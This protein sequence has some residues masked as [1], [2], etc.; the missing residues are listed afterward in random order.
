MSAAWKSLIF[1]ALTTTFTA[2][3]EAAAHLDCDL[4]PPATTTLSCKPSGNLDASQPFTVTVA[5]A[6]SDF[7]MTIKYGLDPEASRDE[8]TDCSLSVPPKDGTYTCQPRVHEGTGYTLKVTAPSKK[9]N[10]SRPTRRPPAA[11]QAERRLSCR[12]LP[13]RRRSNS[14]ASCRA[15]Y[16]IVATGSGYTFSYKRPGQVLV[17]LNSLAQ[18]LRPIPDVIDET[19][20]IWVAVIDWKDNMTE[21][22]LTV[23]GC[24]RA[25]VEARVLGEAVRRR[26]QQ[27]SPRS[28]ALSCFATS[29]SVRERTR[30]G[31][32]SP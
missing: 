24:N 2:R 4:P 25:P 9:V 23:S 29:G 8:S 1:L 20:E 32:S 3:A 6:P 28:W 18:P 15:E 5:G 30:A 22:S 21:L 13:R 31:Q 10:A 17:V 26:C 19:D 11:S 7:T 14:R 12:P 27:S 16:A